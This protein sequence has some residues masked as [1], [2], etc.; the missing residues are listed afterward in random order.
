MQSAGHARAVS[1]PS[2]RTRRPTCGIRTT[3]PRGA[4]PHRVAPSP[5]HRRFG[6]DVR[7]RLV[8]ARRYVDPIRLRPG[9]MTMPAARFLLAALASGS[10]AAVALMASGCTSVRLEPPP[11]ASPPV[12]DA[13]RYPAPRPR[14]PPPALVE[15]PPLPIPP[16]RAVV[17]VP[18]IEMPAASTVAPLPPAPAPPAPAPPAPTPPALAPPASAAA[19]TAARPAARTAP[20]ASSARAVAA[21]P[22]PGRWSVQVGVFAVARNADVLRAR[23]E[24]RL[25]ESGFNPPDSTVRTEPRDSRVHVLVGDRADRAGAQQLAGRLRTT[26]QQDV[27]LFR[28]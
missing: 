9:A 10:A 19:T 3:T 23:V 2:F 1:C 12:S 5:D 14:Q 11:V 28:W 17:E 15:S 4:R 18:A 7:A 6:G 16:P 26:L 27:V 24:R 25:A 21:A 8:H 22:A 20:P 13:E